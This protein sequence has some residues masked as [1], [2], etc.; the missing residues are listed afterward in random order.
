MKREWT[1]AIPV[2]VRSVPMEVSAAMSTASPP[3]DA[4]QASV[5]RVAK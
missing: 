2:T 3:V 1:P 5:G 4:R